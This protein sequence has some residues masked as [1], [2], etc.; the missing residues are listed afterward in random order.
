MGV[1]WLGLREIG[2][3]RHVL[4]VTAGVLAG[5]GALYG[6]CATAAAVQVAAS[7]TTLR[8]RWASVHFLA[9]APAGVDV[10]LEP[11][12]LRV[13]RTIS[14]VTI[15]GVREGGERCFTADVALGDRPSLA[16]WY[17]GRPPAVEGPGQSAPFELPAHGGTFADRLEWRLVPA[18]SLPAPGMTAWWVRGEGFE[19]AATVAAVV[20]DYATYAI[21]RATGHQIG[22]MSVDNSIR[23]HS[24][25]AAQGWCLA[26]FSVDAVGGG[27]GSVTA[28]VWREDGTLLATGGQT[29]VLNPW[30]WRQAGE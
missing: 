12:V 28:H 30:D 25:A 4:P 14:H 22:G 8:P 11:L 27:F 18:G 17:V 9:A 19:D 13:G 15:D 23:L 20:C 6:G 10:V 1:G 16:D 26:T 21:G 3:G 24:H 29:M 2:D 5:S 7:N